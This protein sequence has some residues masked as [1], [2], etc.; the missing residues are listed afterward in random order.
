[1]RITD[2]LK[3][4]S[5]EL[6]GQVKTKEE[7]IDRMVELMVK[8]SNIRDENAYKQGVL[9]REA[10]GT[11]GIGGGIA[12]PHAK[13][14]G[15]AQAGL[16]AMVVPGGVDYDAMDGAPVDLLF[17]IAAPDTEDNVHLQ[18]LSR[19]A[20]LLMDG[21][22]TAKLR[23]A[24]SAEE[25]LQ[26]I[27]EA[28]TERDRAE[29]I[30]DAENDTTDEATEKT[31]ESES[32]TSEKVADGVARQVELSGQEIPCGNLKAAVQIESQVTRQSESHYQILAVTAC[33][34]G[35]AHTYMAAENLEKTAKDLGY[36]I[37]VETNGA[38]GVKNRLTGEEIQACD[39]I[40]VAADKQ[41]E[42]ARFDGKPVLITSVSSGIHDGERLIRQV[43]DG[44]VPVY[45][46]DGTGAGANVGSQTSGNKVSGNQTSG[47][48]GKESIGRKFYKHLM[49]GVSYILPLAVGSGCLIALAYLLGADVSAY[50][51]VN[52]QNGVW[53]GLTAIGAGGMGNPGAYPMAMW[54]LTAGMVIRK[55]IYPVMAGFIA[56]SIADRPGLVIGLAV[57]AVADCGFLGAV[58][59]G[60][61]GGGAALAAGKV[62][63]YLPESVDSMKPMLFYPLFGILISGAIM[64]V[65]RPW[66]GA[67]DFLINSTVAS[68]GVVPGI[69]L[70]AVLG[71][72][73][74]AD[75]GG[76]LNKTAYVFGVA[77][78]TALSAA[79]GQYQVMAAVMIGGMVPP[80]GIALCTTFFPSY[81]TE[82]ERK[83][84]KSNYMM[85]LTFN[86]EGA[87]PFAENHACVRT[88]CL[89]G[90]AVSGAL[91]MFFGCGV[92]VPHGGIFV[93]WMISNPIGFLAALAAGSFVTM[94]AM[95][96]GVK[97]EQV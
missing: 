73:M 39:G 36:T 29:A 47:D 40:I 13:N 87:I 66:I 63:S 18:V 91:S 45:H 84:G 80:L 28:E 38:V 95:S 77:Q 50:M 33:P 85:G 92:M 23:N 20:V 58:A 72:M 17:L 62:C 65:C 88:A 15:V 94:M 11:T 2:L 44:Q 49:N 70:G 1:M 83:K 35:I 9:S 14:R 19:L 71:G 31:L 22:F 8:S 54:L 51:T 43:V 81:F 3:K 96:I 24:K 6:H 32:Q 57:G 61:L 21:N 37:K 76:P 89:L 90:S 55:I 34:T 48:I 30:S 79:A 52:G 12:I 64:A 42:M 75:M 27:D 69:L 4:E 59:A 60:F 41:V 46:S 74:S 56:M 67:L 78:V 7:A 86:T 10:E 25:F 16:S 53:T 97:R 82:E 93:I 26:V 68:M 5:I